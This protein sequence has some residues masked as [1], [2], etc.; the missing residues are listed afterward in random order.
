MKNRREEIS[1]S[2][3][4]R[5]RDR[6][7]EGGEATRERGESIIPSI[8]SEWERNFRPF[9]LFGREKSAGGTAHFPPSLKLTRR[10]A[11]AKTWG[12]SRND[13]TASRL[14]FRSRVRPVTMMMD[15]IHATNVNLGLP[16]PLRRSR[17]RSPV[18]PCRPY[19]TQP[20]GRSLPPT[21]FS[22]SIS[23]FPSLLVPLFTVHSLFLFPAPSRL[24]VHPLPALVPNNCLGLKTIGEHRILVLPSRTE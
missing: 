6:P 9:R 22:F 17:T 10:E 18:A 11:A 13:S 3:T 16:S 5:P 1:A 23:L 20:S 15:Q 14:N 4:G 7:Q 12:K 8:S 24:S 19:S 21:Y 2:W